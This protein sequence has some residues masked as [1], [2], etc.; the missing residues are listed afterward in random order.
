MSQLDY[1]S[2]EEGKKRIEKTNFITKLNELLDSM[3]YRNM[4][5]ANFG[6]KM[7]YKSVLREGCM[8]G[9]TSA[10]RKTMCAI[11]DVNAKGP[12]MFTCVEC[13]KKLVLLFPDETTE[14]GQY[15]ADRL[16]SLQYRHR[17]CK[18]R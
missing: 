2:E 12:T 16:C 6:G 11:C 17:F 14:M 3:D 1:D 7:T 8:K 9:V 15:V 5:L 10:E 13:D 4:R 18:K